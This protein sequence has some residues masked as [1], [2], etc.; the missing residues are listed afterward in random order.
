MSYCLDMLSDQGAYDTAS[1]NNVCF[2]R[3]YV[4]G[5]VDE[6]CSFEAFKKGFSKW[7]GRIYRS[8]R[9]GLEPSWD[10][11]R[12]LEPLASSLSAQDQGRAVRNTLMFLHVCAPSF[13][14]V[15]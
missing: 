6:Y 1:L 13:P 9:R 3:N 8:V 15:G 11:G 5:E 10:S 7:T 14:Q 2:A 12:A 4:Q